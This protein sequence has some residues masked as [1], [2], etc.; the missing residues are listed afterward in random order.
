MTD[1]RKDDAVV[2]AKP[3]S[4]AK[5]DTLTPPINDTTDVTEA[6]MLPVRKMS[7]KERPTKYKHVI[8]DTEMQMT[9]EEAANYH[10][11][12]NLT[13]SLRCSTCGGNYRIGPDGE[14]VW[15]GSNDKV[16]GGLA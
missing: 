8:C 9:D 1:E 10:S 2:Q 13:P 7:E 16:P 12:P 14:M 15:A 6:P 5:L 3:A 11:E 4:D